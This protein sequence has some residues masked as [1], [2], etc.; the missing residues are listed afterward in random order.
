[1][2]YTFGLAERE[3]EVVEAVEAETPMEAEAAVE[4]AQAETCECLLGCYYGT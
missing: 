4:A 3:A 1:M 2:F